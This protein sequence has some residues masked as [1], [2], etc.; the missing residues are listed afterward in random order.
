MNTSSIFNTLVNAFYDDADERIRDKIFMGYPYQI[1][2]AYVFYLVIILWLLPLICEYFK[3]LNYRKCMTIVDVILCLRAFYFLVN[4]SYLWFF[5]YN[6]ICQPIDRSGS[7]LSN[8]ELNISY[9][10]VI[11]KF[12]YTLQSFVFVVSKKNSPVATYLL[13]HHTIFPIML[14][15]AANFYP[16]GHSTFI[17][18]IN[19]FVHFSVTGMRILTVAF[20]N[21]NIGKKQKSLDIGLHV[22]QLYFSKFISRDYPKNFKFLFQFI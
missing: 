18:F 6:W 22:S 13:V 1:I 4:F 9:Q 7:W 16:G 3:P 10:Y 19:S 15:M 5:E 8:F 12:L 2:V 14:W 20:P 11:L 21:L 17:G